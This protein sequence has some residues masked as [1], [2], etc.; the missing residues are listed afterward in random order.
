MKI[1]IK[2]GKI[3]DAV[4]GKIRD[5]GAVIINDQKIEAIAK[6]GEAYTDSDADEVYDLSEFEDATLLPGLIDSHLHL[7]HSGFDKRE[8]IGPPAYLITR[9]IQNGICQLMSGVTTVR[10]CGAAAGLDAIYK[11]AQTFNLIIGPRTYISGQPLIATG[12]HC[13]YMGR[14]VDGP[15]E[16][17][18]GVRE[19]LDK[20]VD[21]IKIMVTGG[22]VTPTGTMTTAQLTMDE[23]SAIIE[24]AHMNEKRVSVHLEGGPSL[25][26]C[27]KA[28][29]DILDHGIAITKEDV[30]CLK[31]YNIPYIPTL[32]AIYSIAT[33]GEQEVVPVD[34]ISISKAKVAK[35]QHYN[36]FQYALEAGLLIGAGTDYK[37]GE[38]ALE[39]EL[40][41]RY[42]F[43][44]AQALIAATR[45]NA[46]IL[47]IDQMVGTIEPGKL[48]DLLIINGDPVADISNVRKVNMVFQEGRLVV[49]DQ[50]IRYPTQYISEPIQSIT[51][52]GK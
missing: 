15:Y 29:I 21:Y 38:F 6:P 25:I 49:K 41:N 19:Q 36:S 27:V 30:A 46:R 13:T 32:S 39:L 45:N 12:G 37:H 44:S 50:F 20:M 18:K 8:K 40:M 22:L 51:N 34:H 1:I 3:F 47:Q 26:P 33:Y 42:G 11:K 31:E 52:D 35:Q 9:F 4:D 28:G 16:A 14:Q 2:N 7:A 24:V 5:N 23:I 10:D 17:M 43:T 48:A